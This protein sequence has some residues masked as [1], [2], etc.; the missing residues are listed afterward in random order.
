VPAAPVVT[1]TSGAANQPTVNWNAVSGAT[2]YGVYL[3]NLGTGTFVAAQSGLGTN[4]FTPAAPLADGTYRIWVTATNSAG[5][6][7][8][9]APFDFSIGGAPVM[10]AE[11]ASGLAVVDTHTSTPTATWTAGPPETNYALWLVNLDTGALVAAPVDLT[12]AAYTPDPLANARYRLFVRAYN[13]FGS[14]GWSNP[15]DFVVGA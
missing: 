15:L 13:R 7:P 11:G 3:I 2:S 10:P 1:G 9:S 12:T 5:T 14:T 4:S 6:S 8:E